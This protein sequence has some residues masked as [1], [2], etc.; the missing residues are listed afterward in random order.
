MNKYPDLMLLL[1]IALLVQ[2]ACGPQSSA[3]TLFQSLSPEQTGIHFNNTIVENDT[4]NMYSFMNIY[5][6]GG[7]ALGDVNN[8][9]LEDVFFSG[10]R[11]SSR[12]Y[13]NKGNL[14][15]EDITEKAGLLTD[16][17]CAGASMVDINQDGW[18]DLYIS[19]SGNSS[20]EQQKNLLFINQGDLTFLEQAETYGLA[21]A[22]QCMHTSF[23]DYD[24]DGD[25]DAYLIVN[26]VNYTL[27]N[28][29]H[30][31]HRMING[32]SEST[33]CLYRNNGDGTFTDVSREAGILIEGYSLGLATVDLNEDGWTD[34]YVSN[35][36]LT[37][38]ILY[39][40]N[41]DGTFQNRAADLLD[42]TSFAG[43]GTDV[44]DFNN[45]GWPDIMVVDMLP[46]DHFRRQS[47]I[48][49]ASYDKFQL[50][51][52]KGYEP[53]YTRNTLQLNRGNGR[54]SEIGQLAGVDQTDWSWSTLFAD[55]DNDGDKD[56]L[57]TNGFLRDVGNLDYIKY[58]Q[59]NSSPF[60]KKETLHKERLAAIEQ[61]GA[62]KIQN[63][64]FENHGDLRFAKRSDEWGFQQTSCSN[65]AAFADLDN[66]GDMDI[67][68]N[69][70]NDPAFV[71][72]NRAN[73]LYQHAY[74]KIKLK[75]SE[76]NRNGIGA[77]IRLIANGQQQYYQHNRYRGYESTVSQWIHFGLGKRTLIDTLEMTWPDG[78][79]QLL[80]DISSNQTLTL[81]YQ[82]ASSLPQ[83]EAV[84]LPSIFVEVKVEGLNYQHREDGK[85]D[86]KVQALLP[87]QHAKNG[88]G[89]AVGDVNA[90]GLE[91]CYI[92]GASGFSGQLFLQNDKGHFS[93][94]EQNFHPQRE[95][96]ASLF[97]DADLDGD[98]DLYIVSGGTSF[99]IGASQ[100]QDRLYLNDGKG[101]FT[102]AAKALPK[103]EASG[104]TVVATD[105]D[106]D[107]DLDLFVGGR[108]VPGQY[109]VAA[110]SY[111]LRNDSADGQVQFVKVGEEVFPGLEGLGLVTAALWTDYDRD[112]WM[113]L[114]L[115]GEWMP[116]CVYKNEKGKFQLQQENGLSHSHGWWN[117]LQAGDF[118]GDGDVDYIAGNWGW[119]S[120]YQPTVEQPLCVY[121]SDFDKNG[122][123]DPVLCHYI[124]EGRYVA[125]AR[126]QLIQQINAMRVR[127]KTYADFAKADFGHS[128]TKEELATAQVLKSK[129]FASSYI[130]QLENGQFQLSPLP[131]ELQMAPVF[132][133]MVEDFDQDG[134]LDVLAVGNS[135]AT[136]VGLGAYD[137]SDGCLLLGDG[138]GHFQASTALE[139]GL[140]VDSD[141][142]ALARLSDHNGEAIYLVASN[143]APLQ[144]FKKNKTRGNRRIPI[145]ALTTQVILQDKSGGEQRIECYYGAGYLS[146][147]SRKIEVSDEVER[148]MCIDSKG[149]NTE[150]ILDQNEVLSAGN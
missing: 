120:R 110:N 34:I 69:N 137:A 7:L 123:I 146:Q 85:V 21:D 149:Q 51:L 106:R 143:D 26:P 122:R 107:G 114:M 28:V 97:F 81:S 130:E 80:T 94:S 1:L 30:I 71:Y 62:V 139:S 117:S 116:I 126:D 27:A 49:G 33:D 131:V 129:T 66:D 47:I 10:N 29:N 86:F 104:S 40:N 82:D 25:L 128:F 79:Y 16:R 39:I 73:Q 87:H 12:L 61:L 59:K 145:A 91:D 23:F 95:D 105:Y 109:P 72:E 54:F 17:W 68:I 84:S 102:F 41:G 119:N 50:T 92:G 11:V 101:Q 57:V 44:S 56:L 8:D 98:L 150:I 70:V 31:R 13:L 118:D 42:H 53:Q 75:G 147:S 77:K 52:Q 115:C 125:H 121:A 37:N 20:E 38:D 6:G 138:Q 60:G 108:I 88:P 14:Q 46:E 5:T 112:G 48:P 76:Q 136:E 90:D 55:Y 35:D 45:D 2:S 148:I 100:Y 15:F 18:M 96:M 58:Q 141:A 9:G 63:Y 3:D 64:L 142:K 132:G 43:M 19:V 65:G 4:F 99:P 83:K 124:N 32:E 93:P 113:D 78:S 134:H 111:L 89:L 103:M 144:L 74:L 135:F 140:I 22:R 36:F 133:C 24:R 67:V 127:F